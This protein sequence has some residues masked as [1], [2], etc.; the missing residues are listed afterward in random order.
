MRYLLII[1]LLS[2][3]MVNASGV[4]AE[5]VVIVNPESG[6]EQLDRTD[7]IN[8]YMGRFQKLPSGISA[9][10]VDVA[11]DKSVFY[12]QLV[13]KTLPEIQSYWA[14]LIFSGRAS[15][16]RQAQDSEEV[17]DI[18]S[19]NKGAVGYLDRSL[20]DERVRVVLSFPQ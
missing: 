3:S 16:P 10:P 4:G 5:L 20:V 8:I 9:F 6:V 19:N 13:K 2:T 18:I 11:G 15:P 14:R 1:L 12:Q 7:V 17:L